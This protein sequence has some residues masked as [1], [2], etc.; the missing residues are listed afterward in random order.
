ME[1]A[2]TVADDTGLDIFPYSVFYIYFEQYMYI[3][4]IA[5]MDVG[6]ALGSRLSY[7]VSFSES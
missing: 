3:E 1:A 6:L 5:F 4:R 2:Y 7:A